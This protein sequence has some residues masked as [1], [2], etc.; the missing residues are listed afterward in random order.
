MCLLGFGH[1]CILNPRWGPRRAP[2]RRSALGVGRAGSRIGERDL[3]S[4][5]PSNG[6]FGAAGDRGRDHIME[7]NFGCAGNDG[8]RAAHTGVHESGKGPA[9]AGP[10]PPT[11]FGLP[12]WGKMVPWKPNSTTSPSMVTTWRTKWKA[13]AHRF[14]FSRHRRKLSDLARRDSPTHGSLHGDRPGPHGPRSVREARRGL[15][16][17]SVRER[18]PGSARSPRHRSNNRGGPVFWRRGRHA[19]RLPAPRAM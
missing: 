11:Q 2:G 15:L 6:T 1:V 3:H 17:W 14:S 7:S 12:G 10:D 9:R 5:L 19:A 16:A 18:G 4:R 8:F 13:M